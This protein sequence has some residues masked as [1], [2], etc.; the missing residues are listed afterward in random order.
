MKTRGEQVRL[1]TG[2]AVAV[3]LLFTAAPTPTAA[4]GAI[5][6]AG[7]AV[8]PFA[9]VV[10]A[11]SLVAWLLAGWLAAVVGCTAAARIPGQVGRAAAAACARVAPRSVRRAVE[12]ALGLT[13]VIAGIGASPATADPGTRAAAIPAA[14]ALDWPAG[15]APGAGVIAPAQPSLDWPAR[16]PAATATAPEQAPAD[17]GLDWAGGGST[18][19]ATRG[20]AA[21]AA[22]PTAPHAAAVA[23]ERGRTQT[24]VVRPGDTLWGI[25]ED[26]LPSGVSDAAV[27]RTW[28]AWWAANR[29]VIGDNPD[30]ILP[31]TRLEPPAQ[32]D[33]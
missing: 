2:A 18:P 30:L 20:Q 16:Q 26:H 12:V 19:R 28:P 25:A 11:V 15:A 14:R 24:T 17:S 1:L 8:D 3:A 31:G 13:V 9:P 22:P 33:H 21:T 7:T 5:A 27:A 4:V 10:A 32:P 23:A 29:D 6:S